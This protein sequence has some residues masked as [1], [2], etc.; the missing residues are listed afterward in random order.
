MRSK[1]FGVAFKTAVTEEKIELL[2]GMFVDDG[3]YFQ[4]APT[5]CGADVRAKT[6]AAQNYLRG[7]F[8]ATGGAI[9]PSKSFWWLIDF[10]WNAGV[11]SL[12]KKPRRGGNITIED[13]DGNRIPLPPCE[14]DE[15]KRILGVYLAPHDKGKGQTKAL[16]LKAQTWATYASMRKINPTYAWEGI[17]SGITK[18]IEWPLAASTLSED[19]CSQIMASILKVALRASGIQWRLP[20]KILYG[21]TD[22]LGIGYRNLF[23][24]MGIKRLLFLVNHA[25]KD[26]S[27]G[28][29]IQATYQQ[30]QLELGLPGQVFDWNFDHYHHLIMDDTWI[31]A[32]W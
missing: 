15:A 27:T 28:Q 14:V 20:R 5:N 6:Q 25:S 10:N 4:Q 3:T 11:P 13:K 2:G 1:G 19:Q 29:L 31:D 16:Q 21:S 12:K 24:T 32:T 7:L 22:V 30:L 8:W 17:N 26:S 18:G 9:H 23:V